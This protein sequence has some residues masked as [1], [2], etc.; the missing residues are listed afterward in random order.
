M[1]P[2]KILTVNRHEVYLL[3]LA[4][5]NIELYVLTSVGKEATSWRFPVAELPS[6]VHLLSWTS[7][8][9][10][11]IESGVYEQLI[12][13][14]IQ[15]LWFFRKYAIPKIFVMHIALYTH[16]PKFY[17]RAC[18][19]RSLLRWDCWRHGTKLCATTHWKQATWHMPHSVVILTPPM[20]TAPISE[21]Q[22]PNAVTVGNHLDS[23]VEVDFSLYRYL[24]QHISL[25]IIG[26]NPTISHAITPA[27][28]EAY[29]KKLCE[30]Q[31]FVFLLRYPW[32][33][34]YNLAMLEAMQSGMAIVSLL[35]P[36]SL[37]EDGKNGY[38][39]KTENEMLEKIQFLQATPSVV[40]KMG[41]RSQEIIK[42]KFSLKDFVD[43]WHTL[44]YQE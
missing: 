15:D 21:Y 27:S 34:G 39:C 17:L 29:I 11:D 23:R 13:H 8:V 6:N 1:Q 12:V 37:I 16:S 26:L 32:E 42:E 5:V 18:M 7:Q 20:P 9:E 38:L 33:D 3:T 25:N 43:K 41:R 19:K 24:S 14:T 44:L 28:R 31:I 36:Y 30:Y 4:Q 10:K 2:L 22:N 40:E 35:H